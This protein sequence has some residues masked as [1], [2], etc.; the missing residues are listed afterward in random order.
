M[1]MPDWWML[2][3]EAL[4][5]ASREPESATGMSLTAM[6]RSFPCIFKNILL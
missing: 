6:Q 2:M 1:E 5:V 3:R 4:A